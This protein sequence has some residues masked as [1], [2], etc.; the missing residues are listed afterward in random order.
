[1]ASVSMSHLVLFIAS[2]LIA[3]SVA[4][5]LV[6]GVDQVSEALADQSLETSDE[7]ATDIEII[8]DAGSDALYE[9]GSVTVLV[10]NTGDNSLVAESGFVDVLV[11]GTFVGAEDLTF[12]VVGSGSQTWY[13]NDVL[14]IT[15]DR[16]LGGG[17]NRVRVSVSG[18]EADLEFRVENP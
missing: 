2:I 11:N 12:E 4:G 15:I 5:T 17:D 13:P 10:K 16:T 3:A 18:S 9:S 14:R 6:T 1:M 8:S 7:I